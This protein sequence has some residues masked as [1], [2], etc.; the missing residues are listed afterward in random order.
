[1]RLFSLV[2]DQ[3]VP[4]RARGTYPR[5]RFGWLYSLA[6]CL[7]CV[8]IAAAFLA[9]KI[10]LFAATEPQAPSS[11]VQAAD[12][13]KSPP[14]TN[15]A[16]NMGDISAGKTL[17]HAKCA[18]CHGQKG[19]GSDQHDQTLQGDRSV[20]QLAD[21]IHKT[22]PE[23]APGTLSAVEAANAASY[24]YHEFYSLAARE[25]HKPP[26]IELSRLTVKQYRQAVADLVGSFRQATPLPTQTGLNGLYYAQNEFHFHRNFKKDR[27][28]QERVDPTI[29]FDFGTTAPVKDKMSAEHF[30]IRWEGALQPP[31]T[32]E[33]EFIVRT[34]HAAALHVNNETTPLIDAWVKSGNE[35]EYR[36]SIFLVG[37]RLYP[38]RLDFCKGKQVPGNKSKDKKENSDVSAS[39]ELLWKRPH[40]P[41]ETIPPTAFAPVK[42]AESFVCAT[43]FPPDD[44]SYGWERGTTISA[45]WD[46]ATTAAALEATGYILANLN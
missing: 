8:L 43:A 26:R 25:R 17:Y 15:P 10:S 18:A 6:C 22:M 35:S 27:L 46:S 2:R 1:M 31:E 21:Y 16:T 32:G 45:E 14:A 40:A 39:I 38:L 34:E 28:V 42:P 4:R 24:V 20:A 23:D 36:G 12:P 3:L 37:G 9:V 41:A 33:Y 44:R 13:E 19:E 7:G 30:A 11:E 29:K 5:P